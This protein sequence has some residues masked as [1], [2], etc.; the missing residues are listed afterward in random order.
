MSGRSQNGQNQIGE[1]LHY[2]IPMYTFWPSFFQVN[3]QENVFAHNEQKI[4]T[5]HCY[6]GKNVI[7]IKKLGNIIPTDRKLKTYINTM[8]DNIA[9]KMEWT[10]ETHNNLGEYL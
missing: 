2:M 5:R 4:L 10:K 6:Y 1:K 3:T 9:I 7:N 8:I